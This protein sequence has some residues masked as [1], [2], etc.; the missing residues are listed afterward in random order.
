MS[1][2][3]DLPWEVQEKLESVLSKLYN[4]PEVGQVYDQQHSDTQMAAAIELGE[5][6]KIFQNGELSWT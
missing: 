5:V 3:Y 1:K 2:N 4:V 6:I